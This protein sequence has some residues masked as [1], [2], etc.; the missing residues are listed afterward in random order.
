MRQ[1]LVVNRDVEEELG[2]CLDVGS[3]LAS[4]HLVRIKLA[5]DALGN[6]IKFTELIDLVCHLLI[7]LPGLI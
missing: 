1:P 3:F 7:R 4:K 6:G 5:K 2:E